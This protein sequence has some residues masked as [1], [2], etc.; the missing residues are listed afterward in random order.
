MNWRT[1]LMTCAL[2]FWGWWVELLPLAVVFALVII[3][4]P[5]IAYRRAL[6]DRHFNYIV[7][8]SSVVIGIIGLYLIFTSGRQGIFLFLA[9][10]PGLMFPLFAAQLFSTVGTINL[11]SLFLAM[12]SQ[13]HLP[14]AED[15]RVDLAWPY[16]ALCILSASAMVTSHPWFYPTLFVLIALA[17][18][19]SRPGRFNLVLWVGILIVAGGLGYAGQFG[20]RTLHQQVEELGMALLEDLLSADRNISHT[21][22]AIGYLGE[23]KTSN[24]IVWQLHADNEDK[25]PRLLRQASYQTYRYGSWLAA[26]GD[27]KDFETSANNNAWTIKLPASNHDNSIRLSGSLGNGVL[28]AP[29]GV[30]GIDHLQATAIR[31]SSLGAIVVSNGPEFA[32]LNMHYTNIATDT[33]PDSS[34]LEVPATLGPTLQQLVLELGLNKLEPQQS[35]QRV[36]RFFRDNFTYS[37]YLQGTE[38]DHVPLK[39]FLLKHRRGHC[40]YFATAGVMLLRAAGIPARYAGGF[41]VTEYNKLTDSW[42]IRKRHAHAWTQV[43]VD[44]VWVDQDYTPP[45]WV[46]VEEEASTPWYSMITDL[47]ALISH[48]FKMDDRASDNR[49]SFLPTTAV[50]VLLVMLAYLALRQLRLHSRNNKAKASLS[51]HGSDSPFYPVIKILQQSGHGPQGNETLKQWLTRLKTRQEPVDNLEPDILDRLLELHYRYRFHTQAGDIDK[52][53]M[54]TLARQWLAQ[55]RMTAYQQ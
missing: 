39:S 53:E 9:W 13:Q 14:Q 40:E 22:T 42:L 25:V 36:E 51:H 17:L 33:A 35:L 41:A 45:Q 47:L 19:A 49:G 2:L 23:I 26:S 48:A 18:L 55:Y 5:R 29:A 43:Y 27:M 21:S 32:D 3:M 44:G 10:L 12:R 31:R 28:P 1:T 8:L 54:Q 20:L 7:D 34:D 15:T 24:R 16:A 38:E 50:I 37:L 46:L 52:N 4:A 30:Y 6:Q 11:S